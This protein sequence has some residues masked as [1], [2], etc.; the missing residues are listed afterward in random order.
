MS[1]FDC[2]CALCG[3]PFVRIQFSKA[4]PPPADGGEQVEGHGGDDSDQSMVSDD[5]DDEFEDEEDEE[6]GDDDE[7]DD[8]GSGISNAPVDGAYD[9]DILTKADCAWAKKL[10]CL[11]FNPLA[12]GPS[13]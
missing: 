13:K 12:K 9:P 3:G 4:S 8:D 7:D 6:E 11:G 5:G 10:I 2:Y 1:G